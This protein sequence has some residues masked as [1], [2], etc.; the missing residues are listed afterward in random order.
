M[1]MPTSGVNSLND[2]VGKKVAITSPKSS[3]EMLFL[4][5]LKAKGI[6]A[7]QVTRVAAGGYPPALTM[8]EQAS[9]PLPA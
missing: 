5:E 3:S 1:T 7:G 6:D 8:L 4:M 2:L 9:Y